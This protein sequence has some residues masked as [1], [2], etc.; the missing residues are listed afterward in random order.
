[1]KEVAQHAK[2]R[3]ANSDQDVTH[4]KQ[5]PASCYSVQGGDATGRAGELPG[6]FKQDCVVSSTQHALEELL[7]DQLGKKPEPDVRGTQRHFNEA[8]R[9]AAAVAES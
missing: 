1:M 9:E 6:G 5:P 3:S 4:L 7:T 2:M 8:I